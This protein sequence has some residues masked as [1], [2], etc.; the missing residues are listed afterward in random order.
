MKGLRRDLERMLISVSIVRRLVCGLVGPGV[1]W[2]VL[3]VV[4]RNWGVGDDIGMSALGLILTPGD[5][6]SKM[7]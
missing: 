5:W 6:R 7:V 3:A 1:E 4:F 2:G